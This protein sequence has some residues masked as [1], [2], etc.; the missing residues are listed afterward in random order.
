M[1]FDVKKKLE[2]D[3]KKEVYERKELMTVLGLDLPKFLEDGKSFALGWAGKEKL[4]PSGDVTSSMKKDKD[5]NGELC[6]LRG[7]KPCTDCRLPRHPGSD[8]Q[9]KIQ[10]RRPRSANVHAQI[11][12]DRIKRHHILF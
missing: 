5:G 2:A 6:I 3:Q 8:V 12:R 1:G 7:V 9:R 4:I 11:S 10:T